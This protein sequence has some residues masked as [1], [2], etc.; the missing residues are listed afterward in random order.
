MAAYNM[1][2]ISSGAPRKKRR[3]ALWV[4]LAIIAVLVAVGGVF[5]RQLFLQYQHQ[6]E[7]AAAIDTNTFYP[8][9][10]VQGI[11]LGG[12]TME[13]A[14][15]AVTA[16]EPSLRGKYDI[17]VTYRDKSWKLTEDDL[18]FAFNT[19]SVLKEA[20]SYARTGDREE[21]YNKVLALVATPK[22]YEVTNT[23]NYDGLQEKLKGMVKDIPY[24]PVDA[25][26]ASFDPS[27]AAFRYAD[28]K[29]GLKV[30]EN[31]LYSEVEAIINGPK[32][33]T[34]AVP[35]ESVPFDKTIAEVQGHLQKLGTYST[36][37]TNNANGTYNMSRALAS[38]NGTRVGPGETFSFNATTGNCD[39]ANGYKEAGA[40]LNGRLIQSYGG[41][42]CQ[43]STTVY[44][45]ALRSNMVIVRRSN[46]SIRSAYCPIGQDAAVSY[47]ELD[48]K[49]KNPTEYPVYIVT[50]T[51]GKTLTATFYG[52]Q[53]PDYDRIDVASQ[54]TATIPAPTEAK[55]IVDNTLAKGVTQ[56]S[57]KARDGYR[58]T[59]Q[60]LFY[61]D[62]QL[63]KTENLSSSYYKPSPAYYS[64]GPGTS[65]NGGSSSKASSASSAAK[66]SAPASKPS[67]ASQAPASQHPASQHPSSQ[68]PASQDSPP[69]TPD[70]SEG[71]VVPE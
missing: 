7:V 4:A 29:N 46:H 41:G 70:G 53:S 6:R 26:V 59:A 65:V 40:I 28:G 16:Q 34:V 2:D 62:G 37:S 19:D 13:Q 5:G 55:Y 21:R 10:V 39:R 31:K 43:A 14:K 17:T 52:Y 61:K 8:G 67:S 69:V 51:K 68:S 45:A 24:A 35:T 48:F 18:N 20:Y 54:L 30:D 66:P 50:S 25:T 27:T 23:M 11:D 58:A 15:E 60:R 44:G 56:L 9:I 71:I 22:T 32:T 63:V 12:K 64:A 36:V 49:F 1:I 3:T 57:S 42:I 47:P 33:G 38:V